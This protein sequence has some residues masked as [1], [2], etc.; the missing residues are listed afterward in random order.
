MISILYTYSTGYY[1][2]LPIDQY[3]KFKNHCSLL[4][5]EMCFILIHST[6]Y[7]AV[8]YIIKEIYR[9]RPSLT[10]DT[11]FYDRYRTEDNFLLVSSIDQLLAWQSG[12]KVPILPRGP[13]S[14]LQLIML[15]I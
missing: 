12:H 5:M 13:P 6:T 8:Q 15:V 1:V 3:L 11:V 10:V 7:C 14:L 4:Y 9:M 2:S